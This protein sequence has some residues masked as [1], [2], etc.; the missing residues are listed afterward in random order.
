MS[1]ILLRD[2]GSLKNIGFP[3]KSNK[4]LVY[5]VLNGKDANLFRFC[6]E[7]KVESGMVFELPQIC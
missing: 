1:T 2:F 5:F 7:D 6:L 3:I 4:G